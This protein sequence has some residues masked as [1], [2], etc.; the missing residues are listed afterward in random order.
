MNAL[1]HGLRAT[2]ELFL[3]HLRPRERA[4]FENLRASLHEDY[5]PLTPHERLLVDRIAI[6]HLRLFRLYRI[7]YDTIRHSGR[8]SALR[9][10]DRFSRYDASVERGLRSLHN[11]LRALYAQRGDLSL[12]SFSAKE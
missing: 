4:I 1:K 7:E 12:N 8:A 2:D 6:Q 9:H 3:A 5:K 10:L 11:R